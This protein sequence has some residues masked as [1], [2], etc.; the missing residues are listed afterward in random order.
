MEPTRNACPSRAFKYGTQYSPARDCARPRR[1]RRGAFVGDDAMVDGGT[2]EKPSGRRK[3]IIAAGIGVA[4]AVAL[5]LAGFVFLSGRPSGGAP[6]LSRV[7]ITPDSTGTMEIGESR[8]FNATAYDQSGNVLGGVAFTW[9]L[10]QNRGTLSLTTGNHTSFSATTVGTETIRVNASYGGVTKNDTKM[11]SI[12]AFAP[13]GISVSRSSDGQNW[14]LTVTFTPAGK[15]YTRTN[16]AIFRS[17]GSVNLSL[18]PLASLNP[19]VHGCSLV[20]AFPGS[21]TVSVGDMIL[22]RVDWYPTGSRYEISDSGG[23]RATGQLL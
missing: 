17:D 1:R 3:L 8:E 11:V 5:V 21:T 20:K 6:A 9:A 16:L 15:A 10:A 7:T 14:V 4:I 2:K 18:T 19:A 23:I 12:T 13:M 22:C